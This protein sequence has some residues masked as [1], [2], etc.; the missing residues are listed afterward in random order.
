M[1]NSL[2]RRVGVLAILPILAL[3]A[4][5][6]DGDDTTDGAAVV[7]EDFPGDTLDAVCA[8]LDSAEGDDPDAVA[9]ALLDELIE[10]SGDVQASIDT[11]NLAVV[12]RCPEWSDP[13]TA[14]IEARS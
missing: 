3:T 9:L 1:R 5:S 11:M 8:R 4:C 2:P 10:R 13:V 6:D 7:D 14:A 12:D